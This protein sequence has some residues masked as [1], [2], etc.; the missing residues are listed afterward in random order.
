MSE[1]SIKIDDIRK[2]FIKKD[3]NL[4]IEVVV[5]QDNQ[6]R[7][8][9]DKRGIDRKVAPHSS[10]VK[11]FQSLL[12]HALNLLR[13]VPKGSLFDEKYIKRRDIFKDTDLRD[14]QLVGFELKGTDDEP[15]VSLVVR[16]D[17]VN[18]K[19]IDI[20]TPSIKTHGQSANYPFAGLL[21]EDLDLA[22][23]EVHEYIYGKYYDSDQLT[24]IE[25]EEVDEEA[26]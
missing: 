7:I 11:S 12:P 22:K 2:A 23:E 13:M 24:L 19:D 8:I 5:P 10:L 9:N 25:D 3:G 6:G 15:E 16:K 20:K 21:T 1:E 18:E 4:K 14:F 17:C 26:F